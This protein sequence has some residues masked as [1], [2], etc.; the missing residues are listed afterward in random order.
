M[1][2]NIFIHVQNDC[3]LD[4]AIINGV[5]F[6]KKNFVPVFKSV[7]KN[8]YIYTYTYT[9]LYIFQIPVENLRCPTFKHLNR[10]LHGPPISLPAVSNADE[11]KNGCVRRLPYQRPFFS[12]FVLF[13]NFEIFLHSEDVLPIRLI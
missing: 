1:L 4:L 12:V 8:L 2:T 9:H 6:L 7:H 11:T 10:C 5:I 13:F 3:M